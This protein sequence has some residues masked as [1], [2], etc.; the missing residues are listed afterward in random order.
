MSGA[1]TRAYDLSMDLPMAVPVCS[2][3]EVELTEQLA[4]YREAGEGAELI[5]RDERRRVIRVATAV[6]ESLI[7]RLIE[8][9]RGCCPFFELTWDRVSRRLT[10]AVSA[11]EHE[12][13]LDAITYALG[14]DQA[15]SKRLTS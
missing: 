6:P 13:A 4:R 5:E 2:L 7:D 14:A 10:V 11:A 3:N 15:R 12:P 1:S 8:V 9:E